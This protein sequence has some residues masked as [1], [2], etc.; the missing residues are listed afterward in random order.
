[1][2]RVDV[3]TRRGGFTL[4]EL[5]VVIAIIAVLIALLLPAVQAAREAARRAQCVNNLKQ[6]G[7]AAQNYESVNGCFPMGVLQ[8]D[9]GGGFWGVTK[10]CFVSMLPFFEGTAA[11]NAYNQNKDHA[12]PANTTVAAASTPIL[13][14]PSD[15][16]VSIP[17][18]I[19]DS[20][21]PFSVPNVKMQY[22]SYHGVSGTWF[23]YAWPNPPTPLYDFS[24]ARGTA[25]GMIGYYSSVKMADVVDGTSNT[26][27]FGEAAHS[28]LAPTDQ[29]NWHQWNEGFPGMTLINT[30]YPPNPQRTLSNFSGLVGAGT[31]FLTSAS[32]RHAGGVNFCFTDGSVRFIKD[33]VQSW[34]RSSTTGAPIGVTLV[35]LWT[36]QEQTAA[37]FKGRGVYQALSSRNGNEALSSDSY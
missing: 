29:P 21:G 36:Y 25:N 26:M 17:H 24:G 33:T 6:L 34:A 14:C 8:M 19:T 15:G 16:D 30:F 10:S 37:G 3:R 20:F 7:L 5:L 32:S 28:L 22:T 13:W 4:I 18:V 31:V 9:I 23:T 27:L 1:M 35:T 12:D 11:Y 2:K